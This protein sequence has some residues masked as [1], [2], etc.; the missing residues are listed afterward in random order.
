MTC[1]AH[2]CTNVASQYCSFVILTTY[3]K[4]MGSIVADNSSQ[5]TLLAYHTS[6]C[7]TST[8]S[9]RSKVPKKI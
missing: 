3:S 6:H 9:K 1:T 7:I 2:A 8:C 5:L 4:Q